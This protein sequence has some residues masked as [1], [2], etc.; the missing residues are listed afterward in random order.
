MTTREERV[1]ASRRRHAG[2]Q[3]NEVRAEFI[4]KLRDLKK[5]VE[6]QTLTFLALP[7]PSTFFVSLQT[8]VESPKGETKEKI[9]RLR[10]ITR[11]GIEETEGEYI[12]KAHELRKM[13][14][15]SC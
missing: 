7:L 9:E 6:A 15:F 12:P 14:P 13:V 2:G 4:P 1:E 3:V 11:G 10:K 8:K 5:T